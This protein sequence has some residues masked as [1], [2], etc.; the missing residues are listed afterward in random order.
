MI[1]VG[2]WSCDQGIVPDNPT[3]PTSQIS[4]LQNGVTVS[5]TWTTS[6]AL[7][8]SDVDVV[9]ITKQIPEVDASSNGIDPIVGFVGEVLQL[10]GYHTGDEVVWSS[11]TFAGILEVT[12]IKTKLNTENSGGKHVLTLTTTNGICTASSTVGVVIRVPLKVPNVFTVNGDGI[13]ETFRIDG[14]ETYEFA[15]LRI[16]N[17][18]GTKVYESLDYA[19]EEWDGGTSASGVYYFVIDLG[20]EEGDYNNFSGCVHLIR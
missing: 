10:S 13:N 14:I 12:D 19:T 7:C 6:N 9:E 16:Y 1:G 5:C 15:T 20:L 3:S 2:L 18:W 17:R 4:N 11:E 8:P